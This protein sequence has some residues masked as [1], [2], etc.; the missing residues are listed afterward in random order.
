LVE[1]KQQTGGLIISISKIK[2][3]KQCPRKYYYSYIKKLPQKDWAHFALGTFVHGVLEHFHNSFKEDCGD[4]N[5]KR[6]MKESFKK[7][8]AIMDAKKPLAKE[9]LDEAKELLT[10]YLKNIEEKG[11]GSQILTLEEEFTISLDGRHKLKGIVDRT[12]K[13][14]DGIYHIKDYK[15][16]KDIKYMD[17]EQLR[18]YGLYLVTKYP[19]V[20]NFRGSYI[21]L[22]FGTLHLDYDFNIEDVEKARQEL[23][24]SA[25]KLMEEEK[26]TPKPTKLCDWCDFKE[27][28]FNS[29]S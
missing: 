24:C 4:M 29:W 1:K 14:L 22:R 19:D 11:I 10:L 7:Q 20:K 3:Y 28:C 2:T 23:I 15:T 16:N 8:W 18:A 6:L 26:W 13:D 27:K 17:H 12:D 9:V 5:L 21:M 25:D